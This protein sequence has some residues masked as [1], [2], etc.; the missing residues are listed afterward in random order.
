MSP[1]G[2]RPPARG[3]GG[4]GDGGGSQVGFG[5]LTNAWDHQMGIAPSL[6]GHCGSGERDEQWGR[7]K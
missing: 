4:V 6:L 2:I 5:C 3:G 1:R 7:R